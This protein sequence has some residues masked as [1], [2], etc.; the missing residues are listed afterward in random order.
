MIDESALL[1]SLIS[2]DIAAAGLDVLEIEP[3]LSWELVNHP[4]VFTTPH[5]AGTSQESNLTMGS[6][7]IKGLIKNRNLLT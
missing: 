5:I 7:A 3:P 2:E 6:A 4:K 1:T